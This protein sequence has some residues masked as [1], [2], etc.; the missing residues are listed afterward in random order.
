MGLILASHGEA[1]RGLSCVP[2]PP[3]YPQHLAQGL[4]E[5]V[6]NKHM[7]KEWMKIKVRELTN[8]MFPAWEQKWDLTHL[9]TYPFPS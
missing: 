1:L 9:H 6:P 3:L 5:S 4:A 8:E 2:W 7:L